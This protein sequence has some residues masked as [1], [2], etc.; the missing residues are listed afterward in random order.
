LFSV[1]LAIK[2]NKVDDF[3]NSWEGS[4]KWVCESPYR[5]NIKRKNWFIEIKSYSLIDKNT[6]QDGEITFQS[7]KSSGPGGQHVNKTESAIRATHLKSG[8]SVLVQDSRSQ[9]QN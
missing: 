1:S 3:I 5:K 2:G 7:T 6:I 4:L 9:H 8:I